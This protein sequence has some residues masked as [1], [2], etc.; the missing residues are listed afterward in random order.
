MN[1]VTVCETQDS[2]NYKTVELS[3]F[4]SFMKMEDV[5]PTCSLPLYLQLYL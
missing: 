2:E 4:P 5:T 3:K 1:V